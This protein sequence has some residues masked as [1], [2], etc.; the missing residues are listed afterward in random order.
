MQQRAGKLK[1][2]LLSL[3]RHYTN[4]HEHYNA[5]RAQDGLYF[6]ET[7][8][9]W[10][11]TSHKLATAILDDKRFL[12]SLSS[13]ASGAAPAQMAAVSKQMVFMDGDAHHDAQ[14]VMSRTLAHQVK[15]MPDDIRRFAREALLSAQ[16]AREMDAVSEFASPVSL[17]TIAHV[18]G[19]PV[20]D[21]ELLR[22]L[23]VWSDTFGDVTSGYF[24]GDMN[25]I[26]DFVTGN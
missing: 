16:A 9:S 25:D 19:I 15:Q 14:N 13:L 6:D 20:D 1:L 17:F 22:K 26:I 4:P 21:R 2:N 8:Q 3:R 24:R 23:E 10:L 18:L 12:S 7:S 5:L 11:V